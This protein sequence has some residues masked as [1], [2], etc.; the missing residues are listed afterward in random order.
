VNRG[1]LV[2]FLFTPIIFSQPLAFGVKGGVPLTD[3]LN[4]TQAGY[5]ENASTTNPY[6]LGPTVELR[7]P[8]NLVIEFDALF[9]HFRYRWTFSIIGY[10]SQTTAASN[11]W[12]F[13]LL[14]KYR[15]P[16]R[17]LRPYIDGGVAVDRLQGRATITT[18][19]F[20]PG[21]TILTTTTQTSS[22]QGLENKTSAGVVICGGVD[23]P[24]LFLHI[25]P[26]VRYTRWTLPHFA[27]PDVL[28]SN[29]N[30]VEFLLG[31]TF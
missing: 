8:R 17:L 25:S 20:G 9:R 31:V 7:L 23:I 4:A 3:L 19:S 13:P 2:F 10:G 21:T 18:Y 24:A 27:L 26:E 15:L 30:Q 16:G 14:L 1:L 29:E 6:I 11:A 22:P 5:N 12:E 28:H